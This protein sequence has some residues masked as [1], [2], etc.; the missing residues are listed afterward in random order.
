MAVG[1]EQEY[2]PCAVRTLFSSIEI[3]A[4]GFKVLFPLVQV[5]HAEGEMV[6]RMSLEKGSAEIRDQV[7][8][9]I[10]AETEPG[11][12]KIESRP[13]DRSE[14][15]YVLIKGA[16]ALEV[17]DVEGDVIQFEGGHLSVASDLGMRKLRE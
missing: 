9:L 1:I 7:Q 3:S 4:G 5:I 10:R 2:L 11:A 14:A 15:Q 12:R 13:R 8:L 16:A 17:S 6:V